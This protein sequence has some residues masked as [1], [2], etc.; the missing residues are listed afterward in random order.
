LDLSG[1]LTNVQDAVARKDEKEERVNINAI[2][3]HRR[4]KVAVGERRSDIDR[5]LISTDGRTISLHPT[6][7]RQFGGVS[8]VLATT[9]SGRQE[10]SVY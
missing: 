9:L 8:A 5:R 6:V 4:R 1:I 7:R 2:A 10:A 3:G